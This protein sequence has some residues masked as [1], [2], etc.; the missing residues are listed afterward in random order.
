[1][2]SEWPLVSIREVAEVYDGPHATP[3][4]TDSGPVF[5]GISSLQ[6]GRIDPSQLEYLSEDDFGKWTRRVL[7]RAG[8]VVFSYETRIGQAAIIPPHMRCC[9]G[10][11]MA[12]VRPDASRLHPRYFLYHFMGPEFQDRLR[13]KTVHGSTVE[14]L[15]LTEFPDLQVRIPP[16]ETQNGIVA[17]LGSIDDRMD[18]LHQANLTLGSIAQTIFKSWFVDFDPVRAKAEGQEPEGFDAETMALFSS[19]FEDT[20]LGSVPKGW[21]C[22]TLGELCKEHGGFLQTGPFGSQLHAADYVDA[23]IPVVMPQDMRNRRVALDKI[24]RIREQQ[25]QELGRHRLQPGD[26]VFSRRGDVG[27]HAVISATESGWLCGT[28]CILVRPGPRW[29]ST[30]YLSLFLHLPDTKD[31]I[32]RHAVGATMPN[33]NTGILGSLPVLIPSA[34]ILVAFEAIAGSLEARISANLAHSNLLADL[35][36]TLLPRLISGQLR[37]PEAQEA[38]E[39]ALTV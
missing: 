16:I 22:S 10:R 24:S 20:K 26:I 6:N 9:L 7:P 12:L 37:I 14:R 34:K 2:Q 29:S 18:L 25:A 8:D 27:R 11:R 1:M 4:K 33:L 35:R 21:G 13:A 19:E 39:E 15:L 30:A 32:E 3:K 28:G 36:D 5:L 17:I 23:G 38:V 31:W